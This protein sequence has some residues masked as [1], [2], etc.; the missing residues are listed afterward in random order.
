MGHTRQLEDL[1][2]EDEIGKKIF[3]KKNKGAICPL[4]PLPAWWQN[5]EIFQSLSSEPPRRE[6]DNFNWKNPW[7]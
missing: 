4:A 7:A 2:W 5:L 3:E 1:A 6:G